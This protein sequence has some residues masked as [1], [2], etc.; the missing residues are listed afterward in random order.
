M[1]ECVFSINYSIVREEKSISTRKCS[2]SPGV[3][4]HVD[5]RYCFE[6]PSGHYGYVPDLD[7]RLS[8]LQ[9]LRLFSGVAYSSVG[10]P[11]RVKKRL[12][13]SKVTKYSVPSIYTETY[14]FRVSSRH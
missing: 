6:D 13:G 4:P 7:E 11:Q 9:R 8:M 12:R 3:S 5:G 1:V 10:Q 14:K 2:S